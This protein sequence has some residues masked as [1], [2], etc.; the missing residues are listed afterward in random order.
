MKPSLGY[1]CHY[2]NWVLK[3]NYKFAVVEERACENKS[4]RGPPAMWCSPEA[5]HWFGKGVE[6]RGLSIAREKPWNLWLGRELAQV[7]R[8]KKEIKRP[9]ACVTVLQNIPEALLFCPSS[10]PP[11]Y[12][13]VFTFDFCGETLECLHLVDCLRA[14]TFVLKHKV[15]QNPPRSQPVPYGWLPSRKWEGRA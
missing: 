4:T 14:D 6:L 10:L 2:T 11:A 3:Y 9:I 1:I 13:A 8:K 12:W 7:L 15:K 5:W